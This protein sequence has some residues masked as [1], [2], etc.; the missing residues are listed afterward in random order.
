MI[1]A[2]IFRIDTAASGGDLKGRI[3]AS[4]EQECEDPLMAADRHASWMK[5]QRSVFDRSRATHSSLLH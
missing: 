4:S 3:A 2:N 5:N 1:E